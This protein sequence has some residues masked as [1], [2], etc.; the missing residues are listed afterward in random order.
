MSGKLSIYFF[1]L[2]CLYWK[3]ACE[4]IADLLRM[5][6]ELSGFKSKTII[7]PFLP[8]AIKPSHIVR[9]YVLL[10]FKRKYF[11]TFSPCLFLAMSYLFY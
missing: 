4:G 1:L 9:D 6:T 2:N 7:R 5:K 11:S 10:T 8:Y 3:I